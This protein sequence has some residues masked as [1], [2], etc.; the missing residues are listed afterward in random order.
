MTRIIPSQHVLSDLDVTWHDSP[1][2][3]P[4][5]CCPRCGEEHRVEGWE[6]RRGSESV[7]AGTETRGSRPNRRSVRSRGAT[8][9]P[10]TC[11]RWCRSTC[12]TPGPA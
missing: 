7:S 2:G 3:N 10:A 12:R 1:T 11:R 9:V 5:L 8:P 4:I 6:N